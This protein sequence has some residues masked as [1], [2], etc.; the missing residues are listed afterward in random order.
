VRRPSSRGAP[1]DAVVVGAGPNGL[2]AANL[3]AD[4]GWRV[5]VYEG[6]SVAGGAVR[7]DEVTRPGFVSDLFSA[8]YPFAAASPVLRSLELERWGLRWRRAPLAVAHPQGDG[9]LA[10]VATTTAATA[11]ILAEH[12]PADARAWLALMEQWHRIGPRFVRALLAPFPPVR[13]G[14]RMLVAPPRDL[15]WLARTALTPVRRLGEELFDQEPSRNL[16]GGL[17]LH[18]DLPPEAAGSG[19]FGWLLAGLAQEVGFPVPE[20]GAGELTRSLVR[21]LEERGGVVHRD[22]PVTRVVVD[23]GRARGVVVAGSF[24]PA[25]RAVL[26][27]ATA[28]ALY[29]ELLADVPKPERVEQGLKRW[30]PGAATIKVDWALG[31][32]IPW[33]DA[34]LGHAGTVHLAD[35]L[36]DLSRYACALATRTLP[37]PPFVVVGQMTT[38]DPIRSPAGTE[39]A[40]AYS[41]VAQEAPG[42]GAW[43]PDLVDRVVVA[44]E[45]VIEKKAP[46][47]GSLVLER[48]VQGPIE[49]EQADPN[50]VGGDLNAGT[51]QLHQ[52]L[53]FRPFAGAARPETFVDALYLAGASAH[54]GGGVHGAPGA[55]AAR[56]ALLHD[57]LARLRRFR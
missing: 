41:H 10:A 18:A 39:S 2:V 56:A 49:L 55:N 6:A 30:Q 51:A 33:T 52:Q 9:T 12:S 16:L 24:V 46:G 21:R 54:P 19:L 4:R 48:F 7:S 50:L 13:A 35:S 57:R 44:M 37:E 26:A 42:G 5:A 34:R 3:L 43:T 53:V 23:D 8:F 36:D 28:P 29:R 40:W 22:A 32:P 15:A 25:T 11:G 1:A 31:A 38:A 47:F 20:G 45:Q 14:A 27:T 17:A